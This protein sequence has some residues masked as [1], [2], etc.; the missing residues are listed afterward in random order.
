MLQY[1]PH[2]KLQM[3]AEVSLWTKKNGLPIDSLLNSTINDI[4]M[5]KA[6]LYI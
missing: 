1:I 3:D 6:G 2:I 5:L 4:I